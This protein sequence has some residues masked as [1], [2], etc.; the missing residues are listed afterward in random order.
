MEEGDNNIQ[1]Q[2]QSNSQNITNKMYEKPLHGS[3]SN[4]NQIRASAIDLNNGNK[5]ESTLFSS[6]Q[7][8]GEPKILKKDDDEIKEI[9]NNIKDKYRYVICVLI[10]DDTFFNERLVQQTFNELIQNIKNLNKLL[11]NIDNVLICLFFNETKNNS[12]FSQEDRMNLDETNYILSPKTYLVDNE[13]LDIQCI[14]KKN[15]FS[16]LEILKYYYCVIINQFALDKDIFS[17][18]ISAGVVPNLNSLENIIKVSY[19]TGKTHQIVVPVLDEEDDN[20]FVSKIK[21][22][23]RVHFNLYEMNFY[24]TTATVPVSSLFNTMTINSQLSRDLVYFYQNIL[25]D[26]SIDYHDYN[27]G[28]YLFRKLYNIV[29]YNSHTFAK[30]KSPELKE[31]PICD[32]KDDWI[33]RYSGYY[34]NFFSL[35]NTF[36]DCNACVMSSKFFLFF[37]IVGLMIEFI[38]PSLSCM[39]IYTIFNEAFGT[40]DARPS[41][42]CT[43]IYLFMCVCS[44]AC[45]LISNNS[46]RMKITTFFFFI[47]MEV[48]YLFIMICAIVAMDKVNKNKD[49]DPYKF[50]TAATVC[51]ILFIFIPAI[52]PMIIKSGVIIENIVPMLLYLVLGA[53]SSTSIFNIAKVVNAAETS[54]GLAY[55]KE[56]KGIT[57]IA[58]VLFNLF[59]GSLTFYNYT[60]QKRVDAVMGLGIFYLLYNFFKCIAIILNLI[61]NNKFELNNEIEIR[62]ND[63]NNSYSKKGSQINNNNSFNN[64]Q[65]MNQPEEDNQ[66]NNNQYD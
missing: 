41:A 13:K 46:Q 15:Y 2:D 3:I 53:P 58:Y 28:L 60:R 33:K 5:N 65:N 12:V 21:K 19:N 6:F 44:G 62:N 56:K 54:G 7:Q 45:S 66:S 43:L 30:I 10:K 31:Y 38:F 36:L 49:L 35:A 27:L 61:N 4:S 52:I 16:D 8:S 14:S 29:Y 17:T 9:Y 47:F 51:I 32:Y 48:Y 23:E 39:V 55:V 20:S 1:D 59:F 42:L 24:S 37:Q 18:V 50:N 25:L 57:I 64:S 11:I 63:S 40:S 22:Y 34:G 26:Q